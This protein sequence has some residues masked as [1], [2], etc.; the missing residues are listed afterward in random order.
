MNA[1]YRNQF[2]RSWT[3]GKDYVKG[4]R[5]SK[6][7]LISDLNNKNF[8]LYTAQFEEKIIACIGLTLMREFVEIGTFAIDPDLQNL[9]IGQRMLSF[10]E[11]Y[12]RDTYADV[13]NINLYVLSVRKELIEYY[14]R[15]GFNRTGVVDDY[16]ITGEVGIP[17]IPLSLVEMIKKLGD[18]FVCV[19]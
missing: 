16:P 12:I 13:L 9:G 1:A 4:A 2:G 5:I 7:Q 17:L 8:E 18:W 11:K 19:K 14:E 6:Q 3:T 10:A 15:R